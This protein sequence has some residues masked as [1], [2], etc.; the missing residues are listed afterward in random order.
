LRLVFE[1]GMRIGE[2][3]RLEFKDCDFERRTVRVVRKKK[4]Y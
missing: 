4:V 1:I 3:Y 2:A